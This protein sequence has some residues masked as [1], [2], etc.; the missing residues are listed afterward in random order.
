MHKIALQV[1]LSYAK[2]YGLLNVL[3]KLLT[4]AMVKTLVYCMI[5]NLTL[6]TVDMC[7]LDFFFLFWILFSL[8]FKF[9]YFLALI[10]R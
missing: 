3:V 4:A 2:G 1:V 9:Y 7:E 6:T 10:V 8:S 5:S